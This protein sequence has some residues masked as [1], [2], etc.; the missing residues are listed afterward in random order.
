MRFIVNAIAN[1]DITVES[2]PGHWVGHAAAA[3]S[4]RREA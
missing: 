4:R 3:P 1:D 2:D